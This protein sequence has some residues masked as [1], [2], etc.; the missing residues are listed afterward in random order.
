MPQ[1]KRNRPD[2]TR[3]RKEK[4]KKDEQ[5]LLKLFQVIG[6]QQPIQSSED[7][8][9]E[10]LAVY[11]G[12]RRTSGGVVAWKRWVLF[13]RHTAQKRGIHDL[14]LVDCSFE[15]Q[16]DIVRATAF[17]EG[18]TKGERVRSDKPAI[19]DYHLRKHRI[20]KIRTHPDNY[21]FIHGERIA[22]KLYLRWVMVKVFLWS[23][24]H[25]IS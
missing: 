22:R 17:W 4:E 8:L 18:K 1:V 6:G 9:S 23:R 2:K 13:L 20:L 25:R 12:K 16:G 7:L 19:V 21:R 10:E 5:V 11:M 14:K 24:W 3:A 15:R